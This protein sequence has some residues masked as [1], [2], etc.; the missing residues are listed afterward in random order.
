MKLIFGKKRN[1][2]NIAKDKIYQIVFIQYVVTTGQS[3]YIGNSINNYVKSC[4]RSDSV[5]LFNN[6]YPLGNL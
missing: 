6:L 4:P 1:I 2:S 3:L 5:S